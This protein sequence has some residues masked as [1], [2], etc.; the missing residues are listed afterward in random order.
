MANFRV[1]EGDEL[2]PGQQPW[3]GKYGFAPAALPYASLRVNSSD[4]IFIELPDAVVKESQVRIRAAIS[5]A[6]RRRGIRVSVRVVP[7]GMAVYRH[8]PRAP[9]ELPPDE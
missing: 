9:L 7:G 6:A 4:C 8:S 2:A 5:N 3:A 1:V